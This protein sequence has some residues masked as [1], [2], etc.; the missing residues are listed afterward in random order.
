MDKY[1]KAVILGALMDALENLKRDASY[2]TLFHLKGG[3]GFMGFGSN[4]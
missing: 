2:K 3:A 4:Q 1:S